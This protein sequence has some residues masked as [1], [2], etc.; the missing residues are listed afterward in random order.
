M[1]EKIQKEVQ[2][3]IKNSA[4][5]KNI[6]LFFKTQ[7]GEKKPTAN[8]ILTFSLDSVYKSMEEKVIIFFI[9]QILLAYFL[10]YKSFIKK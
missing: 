1:N 10:V 2:E 5:N 4:I 9:F 6:P 7:K 3:G 8:M